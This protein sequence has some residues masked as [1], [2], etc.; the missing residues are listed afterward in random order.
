MTRSRSSF[1]R[2]RPRTPEALPVAPTV[3]T[4]TPVDT[5]GKRALFSTEAPRPATGSVSVE[6]SLCGAESVLTPTQALRAALPSLH[7]PL[8][9]R[10]FSS[11]MRCP[12]CNRRTWVRMRLRHA[13]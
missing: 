12:A 9:K 5:E 7:L 1:D 11:W 4:G 2:V 8:V 10:D 3:A 13:K 6:C